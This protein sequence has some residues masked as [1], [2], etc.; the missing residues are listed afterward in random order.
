MTS[1]Q[2]VMYFPNTAPKGEKGSSL[3]RL[4]EFVSNP[5]ISA[6]SISAIDRGIFLLYEEKLA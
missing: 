3:A 6:K 1:N 5:D 4:N 2:R